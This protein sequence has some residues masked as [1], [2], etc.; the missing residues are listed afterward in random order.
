MGDTVLVGAKVPDSIELIKN[1]DA[2]G[3]R[4]TFAVWVFYDDTDEWRFL[5]AGPTFDKLLP[6]QRKVAYRKLV[7]VMAKMPY[8]SLSLSDLQ[9]L[10]TK[11]PIVQAVRRL[12]HTG[13]NATL[14]ARYSNTT[15]NGIFIKEMVILRAA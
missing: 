13:P 7:D 8:S 3:D 6:N 5:I 9:I 14:H 1:L 10:D 11:A 4:P 15:L 2:S 12:V